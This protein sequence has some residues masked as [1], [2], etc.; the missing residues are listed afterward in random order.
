M[1]II[2]ALLLIRLRRDEKA[3]NGLALK[4][5]DLP[6][7]PTE[8]IAH[9]CPLLETDVAAAETG[10]QSPALHPRFDAGL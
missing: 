10:A 8:Q 5:T 4:P 1:A 3:S 6:S 7:L 2:S 9:F